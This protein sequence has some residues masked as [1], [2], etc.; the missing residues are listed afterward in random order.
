V[1]DALDHGSGETYVPA[2]FADVVKVKV[3]DLAGYMAG[4]F[5]YWHEKST[6]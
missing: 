5:E 3:D 2:W 1:L 4:A 6:S